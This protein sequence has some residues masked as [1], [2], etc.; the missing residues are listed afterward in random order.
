MDMKA[1]LIK[2]L[3][4]R[5]AMSYSDMN[6][7]GLQMVGWFYADRVLGKEYRHAQVAVVVQDGEE[8]YLWF[9]ST[10]GFKKGTSTL[11]AGPHQVPFVLVE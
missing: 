1:K 10:P 6:K 2:Q 11:L 8:A 5:T 4:T 9:P 7:P 3:P